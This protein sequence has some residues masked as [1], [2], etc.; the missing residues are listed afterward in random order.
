MDAFVIGSFSEPFLRQ[1]RSAVDI[2][3]LSLPESSFLTA[4]SLA[5][6][7]ALITLS[8]KYARRVSEVVVRHH[9]EPRV[10][11]VY[12]IGDDL[13]EREI[14]HALSEPGP[15]LRMIEEAA[16]QAVAAGADVLI[17]AEGILNEVAYFNG[18]RE[19]QGA[20]V[21]DAVGVTLMHAEMQVRMKRK[22]GLGVGR[23]W[24][25]PKAPAEL[26]SA[27]RRNLLTP[28]NST[29]GTSA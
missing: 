2:P 19:L 16:T 27:M 18:L 21:M 14:D 11:G 17:L 26:M 12:P 29:P 10:A 8:P 7:F 24:S 4:C 9:M 25:Y 3:V 5:E 23:A 6:R 13:K 28:T 22:L 1:S 20:S 15:V